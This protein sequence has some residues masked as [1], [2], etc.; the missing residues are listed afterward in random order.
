MVVAFHL[1]SSLVPGGSLGVDIFFV[2]SGFLITSILL[3]Q[4]A[5]AGRISLTAFWTARLRR[6]WPVA[7]TVTAVTAVAA[8]AVMIPEQWDETR[9]DALA[10]L[11]QVANWRLIAD[12]GSYF[13][14]SLGP[15]PFEHAWSLAVE[16]QFYFLWPIA[17]VL[18]LRFGFVRS[19][20]FA[21]ALACAAL[22]SAALMAELYSPAAPDRAY[23][24]TDT[25][26]QQLLV[27]C[28]LALVSAHAALSPALM[29]VAR[30]R[31]VVWCALGLMAVVV[32]FVSGDDARLFRGG[33]LV[34]SMLAGVVVVAAAR[35]AGGPVG[36]LGWG[37]LVAIGRR[38][39]GIYLWH[40]PVIVVLGSYLSDQGWQESS[41]VISQVA[42]IAVLSELSYR[43][44]ERP[45]RRLSRAQPV[46]LFT[47]AAAL[48]VAV[49]LVV[50]PGRASGP[51]LSTDMPILRPTVEAAQSPVSIPSAPASSDG[52]VDGPNSV[53]ENATAPVEDPEVLPE[54]PS[55]EVEE[56]VALLVGDSTAFVLANERDLGSD[57]PLEVH[58]Y[59]ALGCGVTLSERVRSD[60]SAMPSAPDYCSEVLDG[61]SDAARN[62][63]PDVVLVMLGAWE[64]LDH[65]VGDQVLAFPSPDWTS[66]VRQSLERALSTIE[67]PDRTVAL[68]RVPCMHPVDA[69]TA[70]R[71]DSDRVAAFNRI[72]EDLSEERRNT[73]TVG[74][75]EVL[76]P[77]G[78]P[79]GGTDIRYDGVHVTNQGAAIVWDWIYTMPW[80]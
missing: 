3:R 57:A 22:V 20:W 24:G 64:I 66:Y 2:L 17:I 25:R 7:V 65:R 37:P 21:A 68:M 40:W 28:V 30:S 8:R 5:T 69:D 27:G 76:C 23:Q 19:A 35:P 16:E 63:E 13:E 49:A 15:S 18:A 44:I 46:L 14:S 33:F 10:S 61:W 41:V 31:L 80:E 48:L 42:A 29:R 78:V 12:G 50:T 39:Y 72:L 45:A 9:T 77:G 67:T 53:K 6:L 4:L 75:D 79:L 60:G 56:P 32:A 34:F 38:S 1:G 52:V 74:L 73:V 11:A 36:W 70:D 62:T 59:A 71:S 26:A 43:L 47:L 55:P 58:A 54:R 51:H